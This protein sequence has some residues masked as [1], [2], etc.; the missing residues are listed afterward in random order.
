MATADPLD[1]GSTDPAQNKD[2]CQIDVDFSKDVEGPGPGSDT[3]YTIKVSRLV[4]D[5]ETAAFEEEVSFD[6]LD[7]ESKIVPCLRRST[8]S[9]SSTRSRRSPTEAPALPQ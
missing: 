3:L 7:G 8:R 6:L 1:T 4:V 2:I 9:A 5:G